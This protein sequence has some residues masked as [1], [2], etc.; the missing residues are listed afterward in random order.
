MAVPT[1]TTDLQ[2]INNAESG[3]WV[4]LASPYNGGG[5]PDNTE[6]DYY[7][8]GAG[9]T[10]QSLSA[11]K[12][13]LIFSIAFDNTTGITFAAD[14][15]FF[16]W[17]VLTAGNAMDIFSNGGLRAVIG[18]SI[19]AAY[20]W[21]VGG[22][23]FGRNPYG[24]WQNVAVDPTFA[25]DQTIGAPSGVWQFFGSL[26][27]T[28]SVI[29]KGSPHAVDK[30][31]YGRGTLATNGGETANYGTFSGMSFTNDSQNNKWGLLQKSGTGYLWKGLMSFGSGTTACDFRDSNVNITI[32]DTPR[33]YPHFNKI[34]IVD[35]ASIVE[36]TGINI[37]ALNPSQ[38]SLGRLDMIT[39]ATVT[40]D[41]CSFTDMDWFH[42]GSGATLTDTTFRRCSQVV[43]SGATLDTCIFDALYSGSSVVADS[44]SG[45][46]DC[47]FLSG[48]S[49]NHAIELTTLGDGAMNW[50]NYLEGYIPYPSTGSTGN[51]AIYVSVGSGDL[52]INVNA[53]YTSPSIRTDGAVVTVVAGQVTTTITAVDTDNAFINGARVYMIAEAG[54]P[55]SQ[56]TV[57]F[58]SLTTGSGTVTDIRSLASAQPVSG[59][60]RKGTSTPLYKTSTY[61]ATIDNGTGLDLNVVMVDDE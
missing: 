10:S 18:D 17:H 21:F 35:S 42:F 32:D 24:G 37:S 38:L 26:I 7:I 39:P 47:T 60:I 28:V 6:T 23:D 5:S 54:G 50:N 34:E 4:E 59:W 9:C 45:I 48:G 14:E 43:P 29:S 20:A 31:T 56:G 49:N 58:N 51:E 57:I 41:T 2:I 1:Y 12:S 40:F 53:G 3:S 16:M 55:L 13:G 44:L 46:T 27:N 36:W 15:C 8:E 25:P 52:T 22:S 61:T 11:S 19:S 30:I 33:T